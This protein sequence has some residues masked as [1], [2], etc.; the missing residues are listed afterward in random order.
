MLAEHYERS[1]GDS[2]DLAFQGFQLLRSADL[3]M[4]NL[5]SPVTMRGEKVKKPFNFRMHPK[6]LKVLRESGI[7]LVNIANNHI[8]DYDSVG[9][10]DTIV[11]LDS[12]GILHVGAGR[13]NEEAHTPIV[14]KVKGRNIGFLGYYGGSEAPPARGL[15]PGV[16]ER[17]LSLITRDVTQ[18]RS[19]GAEFIIVNLHWGTEKAIAPEKSQVDFAHTLIDAGVDVVVGHHPH[20]LQGIEK[21]GNGVIAYSLG[22]FI[23]GGKNVPSYDTALLEVRLHDEGVEY[24]LLPV[25][26][27]DWNAKALV[28]N[29]AD[30]IRTYVSTISSMFSKSIFH[31]QEAD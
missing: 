13:N 30:S 26:V 29:T 4:V 12:A 17:T 3:A 14:V 1:V 5:E 20:V 9:L 22:N 27:T 7:G 23:F 25:R 16:A 21:Y 31:F 11:N 10:Y 18:L 24:I 15:K 8:Y 19:N 2:L 28:G 6:F